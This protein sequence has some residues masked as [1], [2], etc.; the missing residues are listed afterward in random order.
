MIKHTISIFL[1]FLLSASAIAQDT[2]ITWINQIEKPVGRELAAYERYSWQENDSIWQV[3]DYFPEGDL[4]MSGTCADADLS[5]KHGEYRYFAENGTLT[6]EGRYDQNV[7]EGFWN[8]WYDNGNLMEHGKFLSDDTDLERDSIW[9]SL[10]EMKE[11]ARFYMRESLKDST[12]EY[13]H[14][15]GVRSGLEEYESGILIEGQYW[16]ADGSEV[17]SDA[18][19]NRF[20]EYPGGLEK[21]MRYL[22]RNMEYP[23]AAKRN[24]IG[25]TVYIS[26]EVDKEGNAKNFAVAKSVSPDLDAEALR[27]LQSMPRWTP[28][29]A[30]NRLVNVQY[31]MPIKFTL[32]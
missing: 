5:V 25:G 16:N 3:R 9:N 31:T 1:F 22:T 17:A 20:P 10:M 4:Q 13:F 15:N 18:I 23:K 28:G 32:R 29:M 24:G 6:T 12:W 2:T 27:V 7:R 26:F 21:M 14:E 11:I 19:V 8:N 30:Q